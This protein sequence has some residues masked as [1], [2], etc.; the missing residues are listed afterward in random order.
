MSGDENDSLA[1]CHSCG[2]AMDVSA[3]VP[4]TN[5]ECPHC[6]KHTR[7]KREFGPYTLTRRLAIGGM[8]LVFIAQDNTLHRE[9]ALKILNEDFSSDEKRI[10]A[11]EEEARIT[12]AI[13]HPHVV[14]VFTTGRAFS[15]FYIA[16]ELVSGGHLEAQISERGALP[17]KEMLKLAVQVAEGLRAAH[18][19]GLIHRDVKP[20]N[21]LLDASRNAKI[22]D[23]GLALVTKGGSATAE[24]LWAT[25]YYVPPETLLGGAEDFRA[26]IYAFGASL[27]HALA[28]KPPCDHD[29][30]ATQVLYDEKQRIPSLATAASWLHPETCAVID[31]A[32]AFQADDRFSSYEEM[33]HALQQAQIAAQGPVV[34]P[35]PSSLRNARKAEKSR[36]TLIGGIAAVT[37]IAAGFGL[38]AWRK[39]PAQSSQTSGQGGSEPIQVPQTQDG[40]AVLRFATRY[41]AARKALQKG[42]YAHAE[43]ELA[44]LRDDPGATEPTATWAA[45]ESVLAAYLDGRPA[46]ARSR[47]AEARKHIDTKGLNQQEPGATF[48]KALTQLEEL[49]AVQSSSEADNDGPKPVDVLRWF[50]FALKNWE[51]GSQDESVAFFSRVAAA[52]LQDQSQWTA[53]Y[54]EKANVYLADAVI[55]REQQPKGKGPAT[56]QACD[57]QE[58]SWNSLNIR[59]KGRAPFQVSCWR[60]DL[61]LRKKALAAQPPSGD[62]SSD[63]FGTGSLVGKIREQMKSG[64]FDEG[65]EQAK[66]WETGNPSEAAQRDAWIYFATSANSLL[67][68]LEKDLDGKDVAVELKS[69]DGSKIYVRLMGAQK[70]GL[71]LVNGGTEPTF[72]RWR[73]LASESVIDLHRRATQNMPAGDDRN[74]RHEW[75]IAYEWLVG[76][77]ERAE[78]A[79]KK[80]GAVDAG[81][82]K[83]WEVNLKALSGS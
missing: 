38:W 3:V 34:H 47:A 36:A 18:S 69:Q 52:K 63:P 59:T 43:K 79:A 16:M 15:R 75:A 74:R 83:R 67:S 45:I 60:E 2:H 42:D 31:R 9:V 46:N 51:Q 76:V 33:I 70:G 4:F 30:L 27:Y 39:P 19:A 12:A 23:F 61:K 65:L 11:F 53:I 71:L 57:K 64:R 54:Q 48:H 77:P 73:D 32:M 44:E 37:L 21:I 7:V 17:E 72:V 40:E 81:Y 50:L 25:P 49:P 8:S 6:G 66:Q 29:T 62:L 55:L 26:D 68:A 22:V 58:E 14:R 13:S 56:V 1:Y 28:G 82:A 10:Q 80:L 78:A 5:V 35:T 20:G 24:E 41:E